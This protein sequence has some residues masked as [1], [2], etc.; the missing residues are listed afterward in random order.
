MVVALVSET[1]AHRTLLILICFL[2]E[3][4]FTELLHETL[5]LVCSVDV[6]IGHSF[7]QGI[8]FPLASASEGTADCLG[9]G[10]PISFAVVNE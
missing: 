6:P 8:E 3:Y 5:V 1:V 7:D 2:F 4:L 10:L 9:H